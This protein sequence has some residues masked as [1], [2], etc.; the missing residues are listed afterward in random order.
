[1]IELKEELRNEVRDLMKGEV[2]IVNAKINEMIYNLKE[3]IMK[4]TTRV[5]NIG[6]RQ[7]Q[8]EHEIK[9]LKPP[10]KRVHSI[11]KKTSITESMK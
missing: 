5:E 2:G 1:M 4:Q 8:S 10:L 7:V 6:E 11:I 9:E 3:E